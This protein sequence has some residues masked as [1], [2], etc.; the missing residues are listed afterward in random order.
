M[1]QHAANMCVFVIY[2]YYRD[3][4]RM[5][6]M[7]WYNIQRTCVCLSYNI[8]MEICV[9]WFIW[10]DT[11][12]SQHVCVCVWM[13][14]A[15][16]HTH[17]H[18]FAVCCIISFLSHDSYTRVSCLIHTCVMPHT[19]VCHASHTRVSCLIHMRD[20]S[21]A[22][23]PYKR[24]DMRDTV[25]ICVICRIHMCDLP[26]SYVWSASVIWMRHIVS[27]IGLFCKRAL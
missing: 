12:H 16:L 13:C 5:S 17:A 15:Y 8:T 10:N 22:K 11:T 6:R 2:N 9:A 18:M 21:F 1:I 14:V 20:G 24:D 23:D 4:C 27:F 3:L 19:H 26:Y 7:K 25:F